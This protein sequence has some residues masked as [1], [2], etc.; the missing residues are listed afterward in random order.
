MAMRNGRSVTDGLRDPRVY[1]PLAEAS[2]LT[3]Y[4]AAPIVSGD[5]VI[6]L[7]HADYR[8]ADVLELDRDFLWLFATG[9][10]R[11]SSV[12]CCWRGRATSAPRECG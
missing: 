5:R 11:S 9:L 8:D 6:G 12:P 3:S 7:L 2:G 4:V 1:A 10:P